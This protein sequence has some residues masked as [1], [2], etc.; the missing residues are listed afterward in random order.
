MPMMDSKMIGIRWDN[1]D[2]IRE[3]IY[4]TEEIKKMDVRGMD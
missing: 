2:S 4:A 1:D 3:M